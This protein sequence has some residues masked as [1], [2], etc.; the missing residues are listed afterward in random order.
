MMANKLTRRNESILENGVELFDRTSIFSEIFSE[1]TFISITETML[2][3]NIIDAVDPFRKLLSESSIH[4]FNSQQQGPEH[5]VLIPTILIGYTESQEVIRMESTTSLYRPI[6]KKGDPRFW[7]SGI[8]KVAKAGD[9]MGFAI[10]KDGKLV[11]ANLSFI[12]GAKKTRDA[13]WSKILELLYG[14][15]PRGKNSESSKYQEL[16][17]QL[18]SIAQ[19]GYLKSIGA[20]DTAV[21][22]TLEHALG[23]KMNSN[24]NP[25]WHGIELKFGRRRPA[26]RKNL[27]AQVPDWNLSPISSIK[28]F[29]GIYGYSRNGSN[30]LYCT[31]NINPNPQGLSLRVNTS[32]SIVEELSNNKMYPVALVWTLQKLSER[33]IEKHSETCWV[34]VDTKFVNGIEYF[35]PKLA[36][37]TSS[38]R[39]DL[40]PILISSGQ[41]TVDHMIKRTGNSVSEKGP[42]WKV[43]NLGHSQLFTKLSSIALI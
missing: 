3:K 22:R 23:I 29:L 20:G 30:R 36:V 32:K 28:D 15:D 25:D 14:I 7:V 9:F 24:R 6:T 38:P 21:G 8:G 43:S 40:I 12:S 2:Q 16:I 18:S 42:E 37:H 39:L 11:V 19:K 41:M 27:F 1:T 33:L 17:A 5:K 31:V 26:Q 13:I 34:T 4:L 35:R 10:S